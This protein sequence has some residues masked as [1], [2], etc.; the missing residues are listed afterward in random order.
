[1]DGTGIGRS[2]VAI[3]RVGERRLS[4]QGLVWCVGKQLYAGVLHILKVPYPGRGIWRDQ[5]EKEKIKREKVATGLELTAYVKGGTE[6]CQGKE[7]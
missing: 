5:T 4:V 3:L 1:M 6:G 2:E 7:R